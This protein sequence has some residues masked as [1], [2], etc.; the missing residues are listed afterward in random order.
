MKQRKQTNGQLAW[1]Q[2]TFSRL[3]SKMAVPLLV[4]LLYSVICLILYG[5]TDHYLF[6]LMG[7]VI[8]IVGAFL[9]VLS[10]YIYGATGRKSFVAVLMVLAGAVPWLFGS[11]I[12]FYQGFWGF[13][14]LRSGFS[15]LIIIKSI[16][17]IVL[18]FI[19]V[20]TMDKITEEDK[21]FGNWI[22]SDPSLTK[23]AKK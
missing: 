17:A 14:S 21:K 6:I 12:V 13:M 18:G 19:V 3:Q 10:S 2:A 8:S 7:S 22:K 9:F 16:A 11:Y 1:P 4:I 23:P 15:M 20:N 5:N